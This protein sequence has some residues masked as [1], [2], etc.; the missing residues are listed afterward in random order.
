MLEAFHDRARNPD[1]EQV[2]E[3]FSGQG[4]PNFFE[5]GLLGS[6][7]IPQWKYNKFLELEFLTLQKDGNFTGSFGPKLESPKERRAARSGATQNYGF[8]IKK[9]IKQVD[10]SSLPLFLGGILG[11]LPQF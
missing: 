3:T 6:F 10:Y 5:K 2:N 9:G 1:P 8:M 11:N 4:L 7:C